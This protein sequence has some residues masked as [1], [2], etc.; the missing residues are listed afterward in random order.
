MYELIES[1]IEGKNQDQS[2][3]EDALYIGKNLVAVIDGATSL[4]GLTYQ[5]RKSGRIASEIIVEVLKEL[6]NEEI[7]NFSTIEEA[8]NKRF[9]EFYKNNDIYD[10]KENPIKRITASA[11][12]VNLKSQE[13]YMVGDCHVLIANT[14]VYLENNKM[15]DE[16]NKEI[17]NAHI[18]NQLENAKITE[19]TLLENDG[20]ETSVI[21]ENILSQYWLQNRGDLQHGYSVFDGMPVPK[22]KIKT[23]KFGS[24]THLIIATDGYPKLLRTLKESENFLQDLIKEDPIGYKYNYFGRSIENGYLSFD[25][26]AYVSL[27]IK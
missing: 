2:L 21:K 25:D 16:V 11:V 17:R 13:F 27:K 9:K 15:I 23:C 19:K 22:N 5:G 10:Y 12:I 6:E 7:L 14:M 26:R 3:C 1:F 18:K 8:I 24:G 4:S 20:L